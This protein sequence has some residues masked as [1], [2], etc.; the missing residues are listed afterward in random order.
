MVK[1]EVSSNAESDLPELASEL[2]SSLHT[3]V[4]NW[5][6]QSRTECLS[7]CSLFPIHQ[8]YNLP[9]D[10]W[11]TPVLFFFEEQAWLWMLW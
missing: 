9:Q 6:I 5:L 10:N 2:V 8:L 4:P 11:N 1:R 7:T 3:A